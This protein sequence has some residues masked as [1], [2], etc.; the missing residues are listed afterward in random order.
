MQDFLVDSHV[1]RSALCHQLQWLQIRYLCYM[2]WSSRIG[3]GRL[4][5]RL[6]SRFWQTGS[7][8][9]G[10]N[11]QLYYYFLENFVFL[12]VCIYVFGLSNLIGNDYYMQISLRL[13]LTELRQLSQLP[14]PDCPNQI[15]C[16][17]NKSRQEWVHVGPGLS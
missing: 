6:A 3:F 1:E 14:P 5:H 17:A 10:S 16:Y 12:Y 11:L 4:P 9:Y 2:I 7:H 8:K 15:T 13:F